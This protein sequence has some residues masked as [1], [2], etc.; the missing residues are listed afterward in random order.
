[1]KGKHAT[2]KGGLNSAS[3]NLKMLVEMSIA[4]NNNFV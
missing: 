2:Q 1:M 4:S 3:E